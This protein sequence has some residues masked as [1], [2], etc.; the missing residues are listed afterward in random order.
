[1]LI[2]CFCFSGRQEITITSR[3]TVRMTSPK[4]AEK[5]L[6]RIVYQTFD[7]I[8]VIG[9]MTQKRR[10]T[11]HLENFIATLA[12]NSR[13]GEASCFTVGSQSEGSTTV[14][15]DSDT[16]KIVSHNGFQV[17]L[18]LEA[19][20]KD[21]TNLLAFK[22]STTPPQFYKLQRLQYDIPAFMT[23]REDPTDV[24]DEEGRVLISN[25]CPDQAIKD[26]FGHL[27]Q[28]KRTTRGP[29]VC[30]VGIISHGPSRS[31]TDK[32]DSVYAFPSAVLPE[33]C[34]FLFERPRPGHFPKTETL[35]YARQCP[36]FFVPQGYHDSEDRH[37]HW[38][39][40]TTLTER[41]LMSELTDEQLL[42]YVML[43]MMR[44]CYI[45][46]QF[47]DN[48]STF[49]IKTA[50][51]FTI[52]SHPPDIWRNDNI[53]ACARYCLNTLIRWAKM[54]YCPHFTTYGVNLF[55]CKIPKQ[56]IR[57]LVQALTEIKTHVMWCVCNIE[58]D[59]FGLRVMH[60]FGFQI[61]PLREQGHQLQRKYKKSIVQTMLSNVMNEL[62]DATT[63]FEDDYNNMDM[64]EAL[65][66]ATKQ[67]KVLHPSRLNGLDLEREAATLLLQFV[68]ASLA[69]MKASRCITSDQPITENIRNLY[70][71]SLEFDLMSVKLKYSSMLY[72]SCQYE[73]A[74]EML[75]HCEGLLGP[76]VARHCRCPGRPYIYRS[77]TFLE[78]AIDTSNIVELVRASITSCVM[79]CK[80]EQFCVPEHL[81]FE[82]YRTQTKEDNQLRHIENN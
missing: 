65:E 62:T 48:F 63:Q 1:M 55:L 12:Y 5:K 24:V 39:V 80:Q 28:N 8:A 14:G 74:A 41:K 72:A 49:H 47:G 43:K 36:A 51:L 53:I 58:T 70:S 13:G 16:D 33:E 81:R 42:V 32:I 77:N 66:R 78:K 54:K 21:K 29:E 17:V 69:T 64:D 7:D 2:R 26:A 22:D 23:Q 67:L 71:I 68:C 57:Q 82:M 38:R 27:V 35:E 75:N 30:Q 59:K 34:Q 56:K 76:D 73:E 45:K 10:N 40:S 79:F 9:E 37:L 15:M 18:T 46:P 60:K 44:I 31:W 50:M 61:V 3:L 11:C 52:E 20:D 25:K 4:E 19:W 6:S